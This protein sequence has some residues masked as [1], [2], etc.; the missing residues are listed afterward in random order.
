[1]TTGKSVLLMFIAMAAAGLITSIANADPDTVTVT[2]TDGHAEKGEL[3]D[4]ALDKIV[5]RVSEGANH[6]DVPIPW[7]RIAKISNGVTRESVV[8]KWKEANKDK[9]CATCNGERTVPCKDCSGSGLLAR[10]LI[11]CKSCRG[12]GT[13]PCT[14][15][16]CVHG[17]IPCP[18]P[19]LKL[20]VGK[21][22]MIQGMLCRRFPYKGPLKAWS[23]HHLGE[24]IEMQNGVPTNIGK[25]TICGGKTTVACPACNHTGIVQCPVC[26][27]TKQV[28]EPGPDKKCPTCA[29]NKA[30]SCPACKGIG[31]KQ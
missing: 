2:F 29:G 14:A 16:G 23:D 4:Q 19:C 15:A 25:C 12:D 10:S 26:K 31:L 6:L 11:T 1:M 13:V 7:S 27:G 18:G 24:V 30:I 3:L 5:L 9:L 20:S 28:P 21:W 17:D 8:A 22:E